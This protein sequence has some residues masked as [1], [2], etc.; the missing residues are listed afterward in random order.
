[1]TIEHS[2]V[3]QRG[4]GTP[5]VISN[6]MPISQQQFQVAESPV[7]DDRTCIA[8]FVDIKGRLLCA[9]NPKSDE[10]I[11]W[12]MPEDIGFVALTDTSMLILGLQSGLV[13]FDPADGTMERM[14]SV[15]IAAD[16]RINDGKVNS[17]GDLFFGVM[18]L[19]GSPGRGKLFRLDRQLNLTVVHEGYDIPNGPA[20]AADGALYHCD[21][22]KGLVYRIHCNGGVW[23]QTIAFEIESGAGAPDGLAVDPFGRLWAGLW[24]GGSL[25][26][27]AGGQTSRLPIPASYVT[28]LCPIGAEGNQVLITSAYIPILRG[29]TPREAYDGRVFLANL[30]FSWPAVSARFPVAG[31]PA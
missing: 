9:F 16:E 28:A 6:P 1:M 3:A 22:P 2:P 29:A 13:L 10:L 14:G 24:G 11:H 23:Q 31:R 25:W 17:A 20:F 15:P 12:V 21:T 18:A 26:V 8:Y 27:A 30:D 7:W 4:I 19:D 5:P